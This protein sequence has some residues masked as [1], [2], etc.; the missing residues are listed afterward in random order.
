VIPGKRYT[1]ADIVRIATR[2]FWLVAVSAL[3]VGL[4]TVA[5]SRAMPDRYRSE[6]LILIVPQRVPESYV[7]STVTARIEDRL[8]SISQQILSRTRLEQIIQDFN[9]YPAERQTSIMEDIV[10][11]MR[12]DIDVDVVKGDAFRVAYSG[13]EPRTVM[14]VTQRLASLFIDENLRDREVI[15]DDSYRFL[16]SQ[17]NEARL[18]LIEHEKKLEE[19]RRKYSG[20]LPSQMDSNLRVIQNAQ[21]QL[22]ALN[23]AKARSMDRR[24]IVERVIADLNAPQQAASAPAVASESGDAVA[25]TALQQLEAAEDTLRQMTLRLTPEHPDVVRTKRLIATLQD[26]A[27][28]ERQRVPTPPGEGP[29]L[30]T[31]ADIAR[32]NRLK[33]AQAEIENIARQEQR[34][35]AEEAR[36][37]DDLA[38][39]QARVEASPTR[40]SELVELTRDYDTL[41]KTYVSLLFKQQ[42]SKLAANLERRQIGEQFKVLDPAQLAE[43]PFAPN[44]LRL[45]L[46][47]VAFGLALGIGLAVLLELGDST[48]KSD[49]DVMTALDL[50]V[51]ALVPVLAPEPKRRLWRGQSTA[52]AASVALMSIAAALFTIWKLRT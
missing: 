51:L 36:V 50:R 21:M 7:K 31:A 16:D 10:G 35:D 8:P 22:Q 42:D 1:A 40:E 37:R 52:A 24:L 43:R 33:E 45:N 6:T 12:R 13:A 20:Q 47:G 28:A 49:E 34:R 9:L 39:Y 11:R 30:V 48:L 41:Q 23:E 14:Q 26:K 27:E 3:V 4:A 15:A 2:R 38:T 18:R 25:G 44:R 32:Q 46:M 17:L 19:Y 5:G 29:V